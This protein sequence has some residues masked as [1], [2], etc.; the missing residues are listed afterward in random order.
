MHNL[1]NED[2][3][4]QSAVPGIQ[5]YGITEALHWPEITIQFNNLNNCF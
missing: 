4:S 3:Y 5:E 2:E 1:R